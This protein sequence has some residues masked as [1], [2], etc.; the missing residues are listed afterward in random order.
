MLGRARILATVTLLIGSLT[1]V[2]AQ[3]FEAGKSP[4]QIFAGTCTVCHK[5]P[6]GL[7][8]TVPPGSL[9]GFLRQH[10]TTSPEMASSLSSYLISNG[11]AEQ[12]PA[13][14]G[15]RGRAIAT[16]P[17][18]QQARKPEADR[19]GRKPVTKRRLG[20]KGKSGTGDLK[21]NADRPDAG[22]TEPAKGDAAK[23]EGAASGAGKP[24]DQPKSE[25]AKTESP[26][27]TGR[28][29]P[30]SRPDP[31]PPVTPAA[32]AAT[33]PPEPATAAPSS[34]SQ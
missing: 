3:N 8:K 30:A 4:S 34:A 28:S 22:N 21:D 19:E 5:S 2:Q 9:Q 27:E 20:K 7:L 11:A 15:R 6:R 31:V 32:S 13:P 10:Y 16:S 18:P 12:Q 33:K 17:E 1:G 14:L 24:S 25:S 29:T 23:D 26:S